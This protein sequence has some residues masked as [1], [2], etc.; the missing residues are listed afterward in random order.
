MDQKAEIAKLMDEIIVTTMELKEN[1]PE[2]Y[3]NLDESFLYESDDK[4]E[5]NVND[6]EEYLNTIQSH[7]KV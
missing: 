1:F 5:L 4:K 6:F 2:I 7:L 3:S